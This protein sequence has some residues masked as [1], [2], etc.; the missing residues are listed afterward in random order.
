MALL[1][2][3]NLELD[4]SQ[5]VF[6]RYSENPSSSPEGEGNVKREV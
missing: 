2:A 1:F 3:A 6:S 4:D 5:S